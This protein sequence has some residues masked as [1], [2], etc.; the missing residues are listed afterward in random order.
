M[1][2]WL[3]TSP[4][5]T[6]NHK[7]LL[8]YEEN[9]LAPIPDVTLSNIIQKSSQFPINF[10]IET[11]RCHQLQNKTSQKFL[12]KNINSAYPV[13][14]EH[15]FFLCSIFL[16]HQTK[17]GEKKDFYKDMTLLQFIDRL[18]SKRAVLFMEAV[19]NYMLL[20]GT[21]GRGKWETIGSAKETPPLVLENCLSYDEIKLSA[22]LSVSS[23]SYFINDG[24]RNNCGVF[25]ENR[26]KV[27]ENGVIIGLIGPRLEKPEVMEYREIVVTEEQNTHR[28]GY[29]ITFVPTLQQNFSGFYGGYCDTYDRILETIKSTPERFFELENGKYFD[30]LMYE[31][32]IAISIDTFLIE[33]NDRSKKENKMAYI[34]VVG[35]GL[36]VWKISSKQ[37]KIFMDTFAQRLE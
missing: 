8:L 14:H 10:P 28:Y 37:N 19:D 15:A 36:G 5:W 13:I 26:T 2:E 3:K 25:E 35:L 30:K 20:N 1:S 33:A 29:G 31:R 23:H 12:E 6:G 18:L 4:K 11:I 16:L 7:R 24:D 34:H 32:R 17:F 9:N 21:S 22:L 27:E